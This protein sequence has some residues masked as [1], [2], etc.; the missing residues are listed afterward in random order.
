M[1]PS[2]RRLLAPEVVQTSSMDCG[3]AALKCLLEGHGVP[4]SYGRLREACQT[5]V[6]GTSIDTIEVVARQ[7]GLAA[8]QQMV[9]VDHLLADPESMLPAV[10]VVRHADEEVHFV[11]VWRRLG[12][13]LQVM[14]PALGRRWVLA[15][16]FRDEVY[17]HK[18][19]V[20]AADWCT[21]AEG[22]EFRQALRLRMAKLRIDETTARALLDES[23]AA[24]GW[25]GPATLDAAVRLAQALHEA[26]GTAAGSEAA[27]LVAALCRPSSRSGTDRSVLIPAPYWSVS[28]VPD[29]GQLELRG[30]VMLRVAGLRDTQAAAQED[31]PPL[32]LELATALSEKPVHLLKTLWALVREDGLLA[33]L[34]LL[35]AIG[36]AAGAVGLEAVLLRGLFD[37]AALLGTA[38]QRLAAAIGLLVF[39]A[40]LAA[41]ELPIV[42]E[43]LRQGR[44][45]ELR[46]RM[47]LLRKLPLLNDR[48]FQSRPISDMADRAHGLQATRG[49]P[50]LG[51]HLVRALLELLLT[52]LGVAVIAPHSV[53]LALLLVALAVLLP[54]AV[55][56]LL[57]ERDLRARNHAGA[58]N[59]FYLDGLLGLVPVRAHRAEANVARQ[60]EGLLVEWAQSV[61]GW[62]AL[63]Q[64]THAVNALLCTGLAVGLLWRHFAQAGGVGGTDLLLVFWTLKLP[65]LG[66][67][68]AALAQQYPAQRNAMLRLLE[69][70]SAP[71]DSVPED[72]PAAAPGAAS[73]QIENGSVVAAG[74]PL[75]R[76]VNLRIAAGE[77]VAI[78]GVS[79]A[80]K[81]TLLG[82]LLG[83][84]RLAG[85]RL[86]VDG[87]E[88]DA[89]GLQAL[90][91]R[92]AWV[93][94]AIQLWNASFLDNLGY[95]SDNADLAR[96]GAVLE[97]AR[98][99]GVLQRLPQGL[100][101]L[102]GEGGALLSGGEGQRLRLGRALLAT[103]TRLALLDEPFRG[104]DRDQRRRLLAEARHWWRGT[105]LLCVTHDVG[106]TVGFDRVLVV[107]D[108]RIVEDGTPRELGAR[109]SRYRTLLDAER[110]VEQVLWRGA[111]WRRLSVHEGQVVKS[112]ARP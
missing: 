7:L 24:P 78:V 50:A 112:G 49:L 104:L 55:Q 87:R 60:H 16:R 8:E 76:D 74:H 82:L 111:Q 38:S 67:R 26:G 86:V 83:W 27:R 100:Q 84:H 9:P 23:R 5:D 68:L 66:G 53:P 11:V 92:T 45:L 33:P 13:W 43:T 56:P 15:S 61:R 108:G 54:L 40:V 3:P 18:L 14:D 48:Y 75:L 110:R 46:L 57:N 30:A 59:G 32:G 17:H 21:W 42:Q 20:E 88:Q 36:V 94:P 52:L 73:L 93:D 89:A 106:D 98:L 85:G 109:A 90:R 80:G 99:N 77:Q 95:A 65:A 58:L 69:P 47:A 103:D 51:F 39:L 97:T 64:V 34:A 25:R 37:V 79:G 107:E 12:P 81:S 105:T 6:D 10:V 70:L 44:Q 29:T 28:P 2:R 1:N 72:V 91:Q 96:T 63:V 102:L 71:S 101:T 4:V 62:I 35:A 22:E 31:L 19:R 41:V